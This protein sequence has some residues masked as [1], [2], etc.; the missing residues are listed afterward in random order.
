VTKPRYLL[1]TDIFVYIRR[2]RP[3]QARVRFDRLERGEAALSVITY[4][5]LIYGI[6]KKATGPE[7]WRALEELTQMIQVLPLLPEAANV[8]GS[9]RA[10]LT[11]RGELIGA[12]DLWIAAHARLLDLTL[13]TNNERGF[14]RVP[15]LRIENWIK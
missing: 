4:G 10:E 9:I 5:E 3:E 15:R 6:E 12:N 11:A 1:D 14:R 13:V 2:G 7:P 8:Y